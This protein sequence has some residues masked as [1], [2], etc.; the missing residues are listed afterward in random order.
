MTAAPRIRPAVPAD[1]R[2]IIAVHHA[3]VMRTAAECYSADILT[4]WAAPLTAAHEAWMASIIG[5]P[6]EWM[7]VAEFGGGLAGF[8]SI[9]AAQA[10]LRALYVHPDFGGQGVGGALLTALEA[11]ARESGMS[12]LSMDASL[13]AEAFY[14]RRGFVATARGFH[15]LRDGGRMA[16][17]TMRKTLDQASPSPART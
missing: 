5:A 8:G 3:A 4:V 9:L 10:Q 1:A 14:A 15:A 11:S 7:L 12:E 2:A 13:N 17:V 16:C 6:G